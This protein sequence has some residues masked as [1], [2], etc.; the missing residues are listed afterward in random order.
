MK[1][2]NPRQCWARSQNK[3]LSEYQRRASRLQTGPS[4]TE[5]RETGRQQAERERDK[6]RPR[7]SI[8]Y[9]TA[10]RLPVANQDLLGFWMVNIPGRVAARD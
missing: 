7:D 3:G 6:L 2:P 4:P 1:S 5:V 10:S 8:L 9:Q